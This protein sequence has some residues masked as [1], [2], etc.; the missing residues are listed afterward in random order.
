[1]RSKTVFTRF[2]AFLCLAVVFVSMTSLPVLSES[3]STVSYRTLKKGDSGPD[4]TALKIAMY[5]LGYFTSLNVSDQY[6]NVMVERVMALQRANGLSADGIA[7]PELQALVFSGLCVPTKG[8][9]APT[10]VPTLYLTP[11]PSPSPAPIGVSPAGSPAP[12]EAP[13]FR[14]PL[15]NSRRR[16][17]PPLPPTIPSK[18][19]TG[20]MPC[21]G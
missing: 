2:C 12:E 13:H 11:A 7:S 4:V 17:Q 14:R 3:E 16:P 18:R 1:M 5:Y 8:A 9:P 19:A 21:S 6:N 15:P 10:P 20:G